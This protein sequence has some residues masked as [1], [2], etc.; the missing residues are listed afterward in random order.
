MTTSRKN[1]YGGSAGGGDAYIPH[2]TKALV[3]MTSIQS[4]YMLSYYAMVGGGIVCGGCRRPGQKSCAFGGLLVF[5]ASSV[6]VEE[7]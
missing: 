2:C 5:V 7:E 4:K 3:Q 6:V 1:I